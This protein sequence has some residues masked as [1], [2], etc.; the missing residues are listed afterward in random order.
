[1]RLH[2]ICGANGW[3]GIDSPA[4]AGSPLRGAFA[5]LGV[6]RRYAPCRTKGSNLILPRRQLKRG[7]LGPF[8]IGGEAGIRT[9]G[10]LLTLNGFQDLLSPYIT[11]T[12]NNSLKKYQ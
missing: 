3:A 12:Y 2:E 4:K 9:L 11:I 8:L 6:L 7:H 10:G 1:M 5:M